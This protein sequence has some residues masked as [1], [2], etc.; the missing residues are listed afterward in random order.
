[1][2]N[3]RKKNDKFGTLFLILFKK[4]IL[5][6]VNECKIAGRVANSEDP[7]Q[8]QRFAASDM[9]LHNLLRPVRMKRVSTV[10]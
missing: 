6:S 10:L 9:G 5:L 3:F 2:G 7:D 8:T 4:Y 1:M